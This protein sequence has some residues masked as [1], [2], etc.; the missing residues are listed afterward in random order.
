M[1]CPCLSCCLSIESAI[2]HSG[3][4][5]GEFSAATFVVNFTAFTVVVIAAAPHTALP[6]IFEPDSK[7]FF[8]F[9]DSQPTEVVLGELVSQSQ[10]VEDAES[11][12]F[13]NIRD[14]ANAFFKSLLRNP[15]LFRSV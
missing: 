10:A 5:E 15:S 13:D 8:V 2:P 9:L 12:S 1:K 4:D 6:L 3:T 14:A 11:E 7:L